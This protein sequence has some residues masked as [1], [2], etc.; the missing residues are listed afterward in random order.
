M[1]F[2]D[3]EVLNWFNVNQGATDTEIAAAM[4]AAGISFEQI[5]RVTGTPL[6]D[7]QTKYVLALHDPTFQQQVNSWLTP[8]TTSPAP[9]PTSGGML[10]QPA[11]TPTPS[12]QPQQT[13]AGAQKYSDYEVYNWFQQ[14]PG[15]SDAQIAAAMAATGVSPEQIARVTQAPVQDIQ[16]RYFAAAQ[17]PEFNTF[18]AQF[19]GGSDAP[20]PA[21]APINPTG[22]MDYKGLPQGV[23]YGDNYWN[24]V[25]AAYQGM[26]GTQTGLPVPELKSW[27]SNQGWTPGQ[28][29]SMLTPPPQ[30]GTNTAGGS[31]G[32]GGSGGGFGNNSPGTTIGVGN[33]TDAINAQAVATFQDFAP[34]GITPAVFASL[35][36]QGLAT[37]GTLNAINQA[38]DPIGALNA[39]QGWT[40]PDPSYDAWNGFSGTTGGTHS[41]G[42]AHGSASGFGGVSG[43]SYGGSFRGGG[44]SNR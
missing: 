44:I 2:S 34:L 9:A 8:E 19:L 11:P 39:V 1:A 20:A 40:S 23:D 36:E 33:M 18:L 13:S 22:M 38:A 42:S 35:V 25:G 24:Q 16:Q 3:A 27:Y 15:A 31:N 29:V 21:P 26:F 32:G 10:T 4:T 28:P 30:Q 17:S 7:V 6:S 43:S 41:D 37:H 5:A 12:P 14:N